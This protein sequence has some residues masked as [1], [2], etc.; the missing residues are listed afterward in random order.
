MWRNR[1]DSVHSVSVPLLSRIGPAAAVTVTVTVTGAALAYGIPAPGPGTIAAI[2]DSWAAGLYADPAHALIQDAARDLGMTA[3]VDGESGSGYLAAPLG[4]SPYP[5]RAARIP[6]G[7]DPGLVIVQGGSND[8]SSDLDA[9]PAAVDRT[10]AGIRAARPRAT[11][12]LLGPG[13][14]PWPVTAVQRHVDAIIG[15]EAARLRVLFISPMTEGWFTAGDV[16]DVI[17][18][19]THHPTVAG[20]VVLG[21][22]LAADLPQRDRPARR[23]AAAWAP[24]LPL[25]SA[26]VRRRATAG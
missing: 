21:A 17:D 16:D 2:G 24:R 22:K 25:R 12:V 5:D 20:D 19:V 10:V 9:L 23:P 15:A 14:D 1:P 13:P 26:R 8:D 6:A 18:P 11:I 4:T 3:E 7:A